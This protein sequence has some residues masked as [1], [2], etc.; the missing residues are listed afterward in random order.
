MNRHAGYFGRSLDLLERHDIDI[1]NTVRIDAGRIHRGIVMP[2]YESSTDLRLVIKLES[3]YNI[4]IEIDKIRHIQRLDN[5]DGADI[6]IRNMPS[7]RSR[8]RLADNAAANAAGTSTADTADTDTSGASADTP[9]ILDTT[10][11]ALPN[12]LLISTGGTIA[13]SVDYRTGAVTPTLDAQQLYESMP[14]LAEIANITSQVALSEYSENII[15]ADWLKIA[16]AIADADTGKYSGI[17]V[18]HGTDT[19]HYTGSF[20][21]FALAGFPIPIVL[22][23]SQRSPDRASSDA[24]YNLV[25]AAR[26]AAACNTPGV[27]VAMHHGSSDDIIACHTATRVRKMHTSRRDAF[28]TIDGSPAF[29][30]RDDTVTRNISKPFFADSSGF[31]PRIRL[32]TRVGLVKYYPGLEPAVIESMTSSGYRAIIFE[33]TGLGHIGRTMHQ[34]VRHA[35]EK[36]MFLGMTS[37][38]IYGRLRMTVYESGRDLA[39]LGVV[40]LDMLAETALVK[41]MWASGIATTPAQMHKLMLSET[42]SEFSG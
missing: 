39:G 4:G 37:Q 1:G 41:A 19:M 26:L 11:D 40:P 28:E 29:L 38:C 3:G 42:A 24:A 13:S 17:V 35:A 15:P 33:G 22:V 9:G 10:R 6:C 5:A 30:I 32:D 7:P 31:N 20:L 23:G 27:F 16:R 25:G 8:G 21:S 34:A 12:I 18:A 14:E 36:E 2:R